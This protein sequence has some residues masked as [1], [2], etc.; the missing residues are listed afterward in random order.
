MTTQDITRHLLQPGKHYSAARM[1]QGRS[2]LDSDWNEDAM[3]EAED[4]R[5]TLA[6][7]T[8]GHGSPNMG[9]SISEVKTI[10]QGL[11]L[12]F[13]I[14]PGSMYVGGLR[15]ELEQP[16]QFFDQADWL[17]WAMIPD[18]DLPK[19]DE[20]E[21]LDDLPGGV[22]DDLVYLHVWEQTVSMV[23]DGEL[24]ERALG[25]PD[26]TT[27]VR[28]MRRVEVLSDVGSEKV[29]EAFAVLV[30]ELEGEGATFDHDNAE[31]VSNARIKVLTTAEAAANACGPIFTGGYLGNEHQ[32]IRVELRGPNTFT[33]GFCNAAPL[34]RVV[35]VG[36]PNAPAVLEFVTAPRDQVAHPRQ[37]QFVEILPWSARLANGEY[38]AELQGPL[39]RID[40][41]QGDQI[42][43][44]DTLPASTTAGNSRQF[45]LRI[46]DRGPDTS[47]DAEM[48]FAEGVPVSLGYTGLQVAFRPG[49]RIGDYWVIAARKGANA[50]LLPWELLDEAAPH[51]T[52]HFYAPLAM[53]HW[54]AGHDPT[55]RDVR[56]R[57]TPLCQ[58]GCCTVTV[59]D[60]EIS[61]GQVDALELAIALLPIA[62]GR[63]C[64][65]PG[66]HKGDVAITGRSNIEIVGCGLESVLVNAEVVVAAAEI[67]TAGPPLLRLID[68]TDIVLK[69]FAVV[70]DA[71][72]GIDIRNSTGGQSERIRLEHLHFSTTGVANIDIESSYALPQAAVRALGCND[73]T[74][75]DCRVDVAD[76]LNY[77]P[78]IVAGG[79]G[80]SI[81]R[82][83]IQVGDLGTDEPG[84]MGGIHVLSQSSEVELVGNVIRNGWGNGITLGHVLAIVPP[85]ERED[86]PIDIL[87][88]DIWTAA[89]RGVGEA[90]SQYLGWVPVMGGPPSILAAGHVWTT[91]GAITG[92]RIRDNCIRGMSL[93]GIS[94]V[95]VTWS[96][97]LGMTVVINAEIQGN[98]LAANAQITRLLDEVFD[99]LVFGIGGVIL[100]GSIN[101][102]I[103]ENVIRDHGSGYN[104]PVCGIA[105]LVA[106]N[107]AITDN[108]IV[109]NGTLPTPETTV[110]RG[111]RGGIFVM[112]VCGVRGYTIADCAPNLTVPP[113][114]V[115]L[116]RV[117]TALFVH[118]NEVSQRV[119]KA[120]WVVRGFGPIVVTENSLQSMGDPVDGM[121]VEYSELKFA[122]AASGNSWTLPAQGACVEILNHATSSEVEYVGTLPLPM[123]VDPDVSSSPDGR[124]VFSGNH[125]QLVWSW[126]GGY[127]SSV[128]ISTLDSIVA[129]HNTMTVSMGNTL[130]A[131]VPFIAGVLIPPHDQS[132][133]FVNCWLGASSTVQATGNRFEE[134]PADAFLS[135][136]ATDAITAFGAGISVVQN[137]LLV[138]MNVGTHCVTG[139][140]TGGGATHLRV[141][142]HNIAIYST[143]LGSECVTPISYAVGSPQLITVQVP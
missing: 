48:L 98:E 61:H 49:G 32:A 8:G 74:I 15:V 14:A 142:E 60:G 21:D 109:D 102:S 86:P 39:I 25:G 94:T 7:L 45:F 46:W 83:W 99:N 34:H 118:G 70:A 116:A 135:C 31:L 10:R 29:D 88:A 37:D 5:A 136:L 133:L 59:G 123:A 43:L 105:S 93:S 67:D 128:L 114:A 42:T 71:S 68:C 122:S 58:R 26:T 104:T 47:S 132:I 129:N 126:P 54:K 131:G 84:A 119:G 82:N 50:R 127:A 108:R 62:G 64:L 24:R 20:A 110:P 57:L 125:T 77:V 92:L 41:V 38:V 106:Q 80:I 143:E 97:G 90:L 107:L 130:T 95:F 100:S 117:E 115:D 101:T 19:G 85:P 12:S 4:L 121:A 134:G 66:Q 9:F 3:I 79:A 33:W 120:L 113:P 51:G 56:R 13:L 53:I 16:E 124:V 65:L 137:A 69:N 91:L 44:D 139:K 72:V 138:T 73:L 87:I 11:T 63:I 17:R 112:E 36:S 111:Q 23:E 22:R 103:R 1:Q 76:V 96:D 27:R 55:V 141:F 89:E 140:S 78:A 28:R 52:R 40:S 2:I 75:V 35:L 30:G 6:E 18:N 81:H